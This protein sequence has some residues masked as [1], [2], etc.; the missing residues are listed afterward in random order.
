[1]YIIHKYELKTF[2]YVATIRKLISATNPN[3]F[4]LE[5]VFDG[6]GRRIEHFLLLTQVL[7]QH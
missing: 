1:M 7:Q 5:E 4:D 2:I 6:V 3:M